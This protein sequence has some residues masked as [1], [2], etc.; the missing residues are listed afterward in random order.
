V[1]LLGRLAVTVLAWAINRPSIVTPLENPQLAAHCEA[2]GRRDDH[3]SLLA[4][5]GARSIGRN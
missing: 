5:T 2:G 4:W 1:F 3:T